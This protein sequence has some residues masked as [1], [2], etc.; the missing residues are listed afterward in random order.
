MRG[1]EIAPVG[2]LDAMQ[3]SNDRGKYHERCG[4]VT[5]EW[6]G[7]SGAGGCRVDGGA[8]RMCGEDVLFIRGRLPPVCNRAF[9]CVCPRCQSHRQ[10]A[11]CKTAQRSSLSPDTPWSNTTIDNR[12]RGMRVCRT[13]AH[14]QIAHVFL[15]RRPSRHSAPSLVLL[16]LPPLSSSCASLSPGRDFFP[17]LSSSFCPSCPPT[18]TP[19]VRISLA[20]ASVPG[21]PPPFLLPQS[22]PLYHTAHPQKTSWYS[23]SMSLTSPTT[24]RS[25]STSLPLVW[26][27]SSCR[28][29]PCPLLTLF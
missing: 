28:L 18:K 10:P 4:G 20:S 3:D 1:R 14:L 22:P 7:R 12:Q 8:E 17:P 26:S 27:V 2:C 29:Q 11:S 5:R 16:P 13:M 19:S 25:P 24:T 23:S 15:Y 6:R 9:I 21:L